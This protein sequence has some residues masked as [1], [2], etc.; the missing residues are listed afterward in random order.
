MLEPDQYR[1]CYLDTIREYALKQSQANQ[2][3][4]EIEALQ[5][6]HTLYYLNLVMQAETFFRT[7]QQK[8]WLKR[9]NLELDNFRAALEVVQ[10]KWS[11]Q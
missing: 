9:L 11:E 2:T 7:G 10:T 5:E 6:Q 3:Q 4:A 8:V 1:Y